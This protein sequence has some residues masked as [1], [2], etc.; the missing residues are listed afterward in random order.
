MDGWRSRSLRVVGRYILV[1]C[2]DHVHRDCSGIPPGE[3]FDY[4]ISVNSSGQWGTY[5]VHAHA[6]VCLNEPRKAHSLLISAHQGQYVDGLRAPFAIHPPKEAHS[7]DDEFTV[8]LGD[9]YH[10]E[11]SVLLKQFISIANPGGA[12][13]VPGRSLFTAYEQFLIPSRFGSHL[14]CS[15]RFIPWTS[16]RD[17]AITCYICRWVQRECHFT[18]PARKNLPPAHHQH[19]CLFSILFLDRWP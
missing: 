1:F 13:P 2:S 6:S 9:W 4:V 5:W 18:I 3:Q 10:D 12:E 8:V 17:V 11:H 19:F 7:Y 14:L 16:I 15:E